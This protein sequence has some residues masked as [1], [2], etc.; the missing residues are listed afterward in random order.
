MT[1]DDF[2]NALDLVIRCAENFVK[3]FEKQNH[4]KIM[5]FWTMCQ[6][7]FETGFRKIQVSSRFLPYNS[8]AIPY[9]STHCL[10]VKICLWTTFQIY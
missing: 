9:D 7:H 2:F 1:S 4:L 6:P 5:D 3:A 10:S 8:F